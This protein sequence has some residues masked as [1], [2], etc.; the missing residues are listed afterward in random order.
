MGGYMLFK[1]IKTSHN[2]VLGKTKP[3]KPEGRKEIKKHTQEAEENIY[4]PTHP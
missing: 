3:K 4:P 2:D 1:K